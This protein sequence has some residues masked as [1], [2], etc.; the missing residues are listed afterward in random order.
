MEDETTP[1]AQCGVSI[2]CGTRQTILAHQSAETVEHREL[3]FQ[4]N[5]IDHRLEADLDIV[6]LILR[7]EQ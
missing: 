2:P 6:Q 5:A 4:L 1:A 7:E 3:Q